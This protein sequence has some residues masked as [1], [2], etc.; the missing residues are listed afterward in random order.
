MFQGGASHGTSI[1]LKEIFW[2]HDS[3]IT[4]KYEIMERCSAI[5]MYDESRME[6]ALQYCTVLRPFNY[7]QMVLLF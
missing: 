7:Y 6:N 1:L 3:L 4:I 2:T 5:T